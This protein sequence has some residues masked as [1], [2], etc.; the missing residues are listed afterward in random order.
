MRKCTCEFLKPARLDDLLTIE[1]HLND[2]NKVSM[3]M[4]QAIRR[5]SETLVEIEVKLAVVAGSGKLARLP[6]SVRKALL[7]VFNH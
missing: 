1:T 3:N 4:R 6:E 5:G 7:K 2:I